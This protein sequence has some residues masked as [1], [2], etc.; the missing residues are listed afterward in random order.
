M[1]C[2][3][4]KGRQAVFQDDT[5]ITEH[6][7]LEHLKHHDKLPTIFGHFLTKAQHRT[8]EVSLCYCWK[9][10]TTPFTFQD[11]H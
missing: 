11:L 5:D 4:C 6:T 3:L 7:F 10:R 2:A 8:K 9:G 1:T